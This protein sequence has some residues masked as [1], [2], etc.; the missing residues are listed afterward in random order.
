MLPQVPGTR[1]GP[2]RELVSFADPAAP[3][4]VWTF[5]VTFLTSHY[6][7]TFGRGCGNAAGVGE[8]CVHGVALYWDEDDTEQCES[9][10]ARIRARIE[11]LTDDDWQLRAEAARRGGPLK[12]TSSGPATRVVDGACVFHNRAGFAGGPGCAFHLAALR[13]GES[14]LDWKPRTCWTMPLMREELE[15]GSF[16]VRGV[17]NADWSPDGDE[18]VLDWWCVDDEAN[19]HGVEP[20]YRALREELIALCGEPLYSE[21][22]AYLDARFPAT[23]PGTMGP[24]LPMAR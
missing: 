20:I 4:Q 11:E 21:V 23:T 13:R 6:N 3:E 14:F 16:L 2:I 17:K 10:E 19:Y 22:A 7:C 12:E 15:D 24:S 18:E 1:S 5:D 8:C 9:D